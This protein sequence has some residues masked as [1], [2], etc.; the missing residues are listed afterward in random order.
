M[1]RGA[2]Q[3]RGMAATSYGRF[4]G[5]YDT[6]AGERSDLR[7]S[8]LP[9]IES[10]TTENELPEEQATKARTLE[11]ID[12]GGDAAAQQVQSRIARTRNSA[13]SFGALT[14]AA[15]ERE[16]TKAGAIRDL[17]GQRLQRRQGALQ[18]LQQMYGI[19]TNM[20][21]HLGQ[22]QLGA[23]GAF[24]EGTKSG[25]SLGPLGNWG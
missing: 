14:E 25:V 1:G 12:A 13:G 3:L 5:D 20:L 24:G 10:M 18:Q 17:A 8:L 16:R 21:G 22:L 6:A 4:L 2:S 7:S 11:A 9:R 23:L 15:G 19:D